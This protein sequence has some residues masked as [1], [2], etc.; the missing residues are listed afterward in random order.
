MNCALFIAQS[1]LETHTVEIFSAFV[2]FFADFDAENVCA[3]NQ[4]RKADGKKKKLTEL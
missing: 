2:F 3:K 1:L 4:Y